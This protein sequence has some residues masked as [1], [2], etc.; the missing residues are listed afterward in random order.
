MPKK[1]ANVSDCLNLIRQ[2]FDKMNKH[3]FYEL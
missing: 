3:E 2:I 1:Y